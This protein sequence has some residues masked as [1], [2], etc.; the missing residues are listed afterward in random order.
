MPIAAEDDPNI[1]PRIQ[2]RAGDE[3]EASDE[4]DHDDNLEEL[5]NETMSDEQLQVRDSSAIDKYLK[6]NLVCT[7]VNAFHSRADQYIAGHPQGTLQA[8]IQDQDRK[9]VACRAEAGFQQ[10]R[11]DLS[12]EH[13]EEIRS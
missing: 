7:T 3:G 2:S 13:G 8:P 9:P 1:D 5:V 4:E 11:I 12:K 10:I 6:E